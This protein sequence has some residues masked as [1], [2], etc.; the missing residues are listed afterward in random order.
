M[1]AYRNPSALYK[2]TANSANGII[3]Y[4]LQRDGDRKRSKIVLNRSH[5]MYNNALCISAEMAARVMV[6]S[7]CVGC[8]ST[9]ATTDFYE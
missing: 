1:T 4:V 2:D 5:D 9:T 3:T 8:W 6:R 7:L